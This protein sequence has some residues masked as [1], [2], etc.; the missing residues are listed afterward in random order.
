M[1]FDELEQQVETF[2]RCQIGVELIV[3]LV[4]S[5]KGREN[6]GDALHEPQS[7]TP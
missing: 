1:A 3:R 5:I 7:T 2:L 4:G 6:S